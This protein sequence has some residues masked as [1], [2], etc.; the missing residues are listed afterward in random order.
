MRVRVR[1]CVR[2]RVRVRVRARV[3]V[4]LLLPLLVLGAASNIYSR[5]QFHQFAQAHYPTTTA[6]VANTTNT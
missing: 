1:V 4:R 6:M 3:F 5:G 2:V